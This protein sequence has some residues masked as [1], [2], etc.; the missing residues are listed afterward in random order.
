MYIYMV[1]CYGQLR[2]SNAGDEGLS[3]RTPTFLRQHIAEM[4]RYLRFAGGMVMFRLPSWTVIVT[5]FIL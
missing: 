3:V 1:S 5:R 2:A 4:C